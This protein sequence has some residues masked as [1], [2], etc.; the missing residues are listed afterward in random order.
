MILWSCYYEDSDSI[1]VRCGL[2]FC[3]SNK[4]SGDA[5]AAR[6]GLLK[7]LEIG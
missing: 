4:L 3:I 5:D 6:P 2:G 1:G 7:A